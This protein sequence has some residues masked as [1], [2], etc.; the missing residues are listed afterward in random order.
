MA[1]IDYTEWSKHFLGQLRDAHLEDGS[2]VQ[3][4]SA[5]E[6]ASVT[7]QCGN[8]LPESYRAFLAVMGKCAGHFMRGTTAFFPSILALRK[9]AIALLSDTAGAPT[10]AANA[11]VFAMHEGYHFWW[12]AAEAESSDPVVFHYMEGDLHFSSEQMKFTEF[13]V[14]RMKQDVDALKR[15]KL[16]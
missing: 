16:I 9:E 5:R 15:A 11:F 8:A 4:C 13:L 12:F 14:H 10:L 2:A 7:A 1:T 6:I 3:G